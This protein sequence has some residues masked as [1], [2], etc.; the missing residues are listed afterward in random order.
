MSTPKYTKHERIWLKSDPSLNE[1]WLQDRIDDDPTILT[2]ISSPN[3]DTFDKSRFRCIYGWYE[4]PSI[5]ALQSRDRHGQ[6]TVYMAHA[7]IK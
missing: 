3:L 6:H 7:T 4:Q 2:V 5:A 1:R